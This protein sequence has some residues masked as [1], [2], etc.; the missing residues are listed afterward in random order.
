MSRTLVVVCAVALS[1]APQLMDHAAA[2]GPVELSLEDFAVIHSDATSLGPRV[3]LQY[4]LPARLMGV[5]VDA[6]TLHIAGRVRVPA[7]H[8]IRRVQLKCSGAAEEWDSATVD[9]G[10]P[11]SEPGGVWNEGNMR[12]NLA[13]VGDSEDIAIDVTDLVQ[14][15]VD[16]PEGNVGLALGRDARTPGSITVDLPGGRRGEHWAPR[17]LVHYSLRDR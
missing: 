13:D 7:G 11:W 9:W 10:Y 4:G 2:I 8:R 12:V 1:L 3:L 16:N 15:W 17:I 14:A 6:A 5:D